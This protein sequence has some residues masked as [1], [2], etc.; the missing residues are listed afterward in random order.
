VLRIAQE[1]LTNVLKHARA[2]R[3]RVRLGVA[4][5]QLDLEVQDDGIGQAT[6]SGGGGR[7]I[8]R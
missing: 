6:A 7:D 1:A 8:S 4:A 2:H 3:V 5:G